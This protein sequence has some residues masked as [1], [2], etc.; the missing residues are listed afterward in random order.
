MFNKTKINGKKGLLLIQQDMNLFHF[1]QPTESA[2]SLCV[3][4]Q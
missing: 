1:I 2:H 4:P 3:L